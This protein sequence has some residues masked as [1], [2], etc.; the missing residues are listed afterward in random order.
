M[1]SNTKS[2]DKAL[3]W[4]DLLRETFPDDDDLPSNLVALMLQLSQDA[5]RVGGSVSRPAETLRA[6]S[7]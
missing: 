6:R 3:L 5:L 7:R 4:G 2:N 1:Q